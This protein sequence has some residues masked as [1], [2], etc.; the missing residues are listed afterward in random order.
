LEDEMKSFTTRI[1]LTFALTAVMSVMAMAGVKKDTVKFTHDTNVNGT[2]VK[3]GDYKV[4]YDD[5]SNELTIW[6]GK[7]ALAKATVRAGEHTFK[8]SNITV[9][10]KQKDNNF[11]L[12]SVTFAGQDQ[13]LV[14]EATE[15]K[16]VPPLPAL[17][18]VDLSALASLQ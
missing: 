2:V 4:T 9:G 8:A 11:V 5:Q 14:L 13:P 15:T 6:A 16:S 3:K 7:E 10:L 17:P 18:S 12:T 1:V